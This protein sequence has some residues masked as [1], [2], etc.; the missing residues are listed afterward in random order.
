MYKA[1]NY[2]AP[3][4]VTAPTSEPISVAEAK[5]QLELAPSDD[6][7][8]DH[9]AI[10]IAAAREQF[11]HDTDRAMCYQTWKIN[12]DCFYD[13]LTLPKKP[14]QSITTVKYYDSTNTQQT[15]SS[16]LYQLD[17]AKSQI[18]VAYLASIPQALDRWD[19]WEITYRLGYSSDSTSVPSIAKQ[20]MLLLVGYYFDGNR[21]E[22]DRPND[23][24][25]YESLV[26]RFIRASYP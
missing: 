7:H 25:A 1:E 8:D 24:K 12:T 9:L 5:K 10:I 18:R 11:E 22:N 4:L 2:L 23:M 20:A 14:V 16:S 19:A 3:T 17:A 6:A 26:A 21:G 13:G 15:L